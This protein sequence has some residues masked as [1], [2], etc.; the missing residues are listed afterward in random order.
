MLTT[1]EKQATVGMT[2]IAGTPEKLEILVA[3]RTSTTVGAIAT[4]ETL[5]TAGITG[6]VR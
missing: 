3:E 6:Y 1:L 2:A 4:A 5:A